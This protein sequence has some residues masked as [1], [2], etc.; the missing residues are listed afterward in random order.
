VILKE[1]PELFAVSL[2]EELEPMAHDFTYGMQNSIVQLSEE[3]D[4][5]QR[6]L[7]EQRVL[8][9]SDLE[10]SGQV[11]IK[12]STDNLI[13]LIKSISRVFI[14]LVVVLTAVFFGLPFALGFLLGKWRVKSKIEKE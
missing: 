2:R 8:L 7:A 5:L 6:Y 12:E 1:S 11:L 14:I 4:E 3:R 9:K 13:R 10:E